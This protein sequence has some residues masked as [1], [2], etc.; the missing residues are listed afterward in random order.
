M[1]AG[2]YR[3]TRH[4]LIVALA[5]WPAAALAQESPA[6]AADLKLPQINNFAP[7]KEDKPL[8]LGDGQIT[9]SAQLTEDGTEITRGLVW[10]V[11]RPEAGDDGKLP[12][13]ASA[14]GGTS[15]FTLDPGSYLVH[16]SFGRAGATKRITVTK[17]ARRENLVLDAGGLKLDAVLAGGVKIPPEKLRFSIYEVGA[18]DDDD[19]ALIIPDVKPGAVVG[20]NAGT[21][22]VVS[23]YGSVNA[24]IRSDI[25]VEA[26]KLTE[27]TVE[28]RAAELTMKLVRDHG[29]EAIADTS[30]SILTNSGDPI[31]ETVGAFASMVL[32]EGDYTIVAKNRDRIYQRDFTVEGG[33]NTEVEVLAT[34]ATATGDDIID[35]AD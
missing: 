9:L 11:F 10:R 22:H 12:L 28:H 26:G 15:A 21:Y 13:V 4:C 5:V 1:F 30:W 32:A 27:A 31:R 8:A 29:G 19:R 34:E 16:A 23:T 33:H 3:F 17:T 7:A 2:L 14:Q 18:A 20:L 6:P 25:R 35:G 24:I